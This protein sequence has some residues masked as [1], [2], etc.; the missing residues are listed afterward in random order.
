[1][2]KVIFWSPEA[3]MTGNT[4]IA[5]A[6]CTLMGI[7]HKPKCLL[8]QGHFNSRK[9]ESSYTSNDEL[10]ASGTL[11]NSDIGIGA[12][13]KIISSNKLTS[14]TIKNYAK[15]VLKDRLDI[16]YGMNSRDKDQYLQMVEK[17]TFIV[18]KA[19]E[20]YDIVF[21]DLP[22]TNNEAYIVDTLKES[23][24]VV[25]IVNQD[26]LKLDEFFKLVENEAELKDK[27]KIYVI[28]DYEYKSKYNAINIKNKYKIKDP[29][30]VVPH[31]YLF[32]DSCNDGQ[33]I[34]YM[35]KNINAE[36]NDYNGMFIQETLRIVNQILDISKIKDS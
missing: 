11:D 32:S 27:S 12:L 25:C 31:N 1:M 16:L 5:V 10:K 19:N 17:L 2:A 4:H 15:P 7:L 18:N 35:F 28:G 34:D 26:I 14:E 36:K 23:D 29:I 30:F 20:I 9:I 3:N 13:T 22:K 21:V 33:V 6:V 8:M 24:I